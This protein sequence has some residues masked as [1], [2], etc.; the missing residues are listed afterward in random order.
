[1]FKCLRLLI[2]TTPFI[3]AGIPAE[4]LVLAI[5]TP[6]YRRIMAQWS[7]IDRDRRSVR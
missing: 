2:G 6:E 3:P 5:T 4:R 1:M 7:A